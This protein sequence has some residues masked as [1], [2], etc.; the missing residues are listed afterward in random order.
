MLAFSR[1]TLRGVGVLII[2]SV[3]T[4]FQALKQCSIGADWRSRKGL[5]EPPQGRHAQ[6]LV[7]FAIAEPT[8]EEFEDGLWLNIRIEGGESEEVVLRSVADC[9]TEAQRVAEK[10]YE[11]NQERLAEV[12]TGLMEQWESRDVSYVPLENDQV[13]DEPADGLVLDMDF[14]GG[15][16]QV[17]IRFEDDVYSEA[18]RLA[19]T[20][21]E[22]NVEVYEDL[23]AQLMKQWETWLSGG[24]GDVITFEPAETG[25]TETGSAGPEDSFEPIESQ[26]IL[27]SQDDSL[28]TGFTIEMNLDDGGTEQVVLR[29]KDD[30]YTEAARVAEKHFGNNQEILEAIQAE[31]VEQWAVWLERVK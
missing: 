10:H 24:A 26:A 19:E 2:C 27:D 13:Y 16:E 11:G 22:S 20:H 14:E 18:W 30:S 9:Y 3:A 15:A 17:H 31:L 21:F 5:C 25:S 6:H 23:L 12:L 8:E 1:L 4:S 7:A 28:G 29:C